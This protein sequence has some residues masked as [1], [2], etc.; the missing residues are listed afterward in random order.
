MLK[1]C[2]KQRFCD[3][4]L[5][6]GRDETVEWASRV[7][8]RRHRRSDQQPATSI[9]TQNETNQAM[10]QRLEGSTTAQQ[11]AMAEPQ[12]RFIARGFAKHRDRSIL[13]VCSSGPFGKGQLLTKHIF[14]ESIVSFCPVIVW[15]V[16]LCHI[17]VK[18]N[19]ESYHCSFGL[20]PCP[21][22]SC[23]WSHA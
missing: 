14:P 13:N 23:C 12:L 4:N 16:A 22:L 7:D 10:L 2:K 5:K 8:N 19:L 15:F 17:T 18:I 6:E 9:G 20:F 1:A 11:Y 3:C 21:S